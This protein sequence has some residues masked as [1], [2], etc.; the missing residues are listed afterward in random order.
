MY[1]SLDRRLSC[2]N[3]HRNGKGVSVE[4]LNQL[5]KGTD[6]TRPVIWLPSY[7]FKNWDGL[8]MIRIKVWVTNRIPELVARWCFDLIYETRVIP[9]YIGIDNGSKTGT[10]AT[11]HCFLRR[12]HSDIETDYYY[13]C[14]YY[15]YYYY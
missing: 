4:M 8:K 1:T 5:F 2:F 15:Y 6:G 3:I 7:A 13:Y 12:Q 14:Y 9:N 11:T 10:I